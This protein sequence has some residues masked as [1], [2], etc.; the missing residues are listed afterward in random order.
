MKFELLLSLPPHLIF[1]SEAHRRDEVLAR[2]FRCVFAR[3]L[4]CS[5]LLPT[6]C[7]LWPLDRCLFHLIVCGCHWI[8]A[9][10][11]RVLHTSIVIGIVKLPHR[12]SI[13]H[14][15]IT[16][17]LGCCSKRAPFA[18]IARVLGR[19][20]LRFYNVPVKIII[21]CLDIT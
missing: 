1:L 19:S 20:L 13:D 10:R 6:N 7:S 17:R 8:W 2:G 3:A 5:T 15:L 4:C 16:S 12:T 11:S 14:G 18:R 21:G 9:D